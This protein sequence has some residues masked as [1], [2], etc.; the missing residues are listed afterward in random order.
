M[1][2]NGLLI[3]VSRFLIENGMKRET[4][5]RL[6][7]NISYFIDKGG[8]DDPTGW[9]IS[10]MDRDISSSYKYQMYYAVKWYLKFKGVDWEFKRPKHHRNVRQNLS[11]EKCALLL[12]NIQDPEHKLMVET[13]LLTGLRPNELLSLKSGDI[14]NYDSVVK[15]RNTKTY[16]DREVPIPRELCAKLLLWIESGNI[17]G[18]IFPYRPDWFTRIVRNAGRKGGFRATPYMLR[19]SFATMY[20]ENGGNILAL[21]KI[22][23][24]SQLSTTESY[25]HESKAMLRRDYEKAKPR[26][27]V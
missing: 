8:T 26:I 16:M 1:R 4:A 6:L 23:G 12:R 22:M 19:H 2:D 5:E 17:T 15:I 3:F 24:H 14:D 21:K 13:A 27:F 9:F 18:L 20:V 11:I 7:R 25:V 10:F